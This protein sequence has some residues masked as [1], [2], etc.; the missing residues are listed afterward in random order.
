M[1]CD[2]SVII[3]TFNEE[4]N[5]TYAL[6]S[7]CGWAR[8]VLIFDSFSTDR[9]VE[10]ARA[11]ECHVLQNRFEDYGK[12]RNA[13]LDKLPIETEWVF[14]LDA[15]E[16]LPDD[17]KVKVAR[18]VAS[19]PVEDGFFCKRKLFWMGA[20]VRRG[21]YPTWILR[22]FR[23]GKARCE[24][25]TVN[26]HL[27]LDGKAGYLDADFIHE[28]RNGLPR[29]IEKHRRYAERE[30]HELLAGPTTGAIEPRLLGSQAERKRWLRERVWNRLPPLVRPFGYF[31]YR[32]VLRGGMLDGLA[33]LTYH[34][35]QG[36][37][38]PLLID[39]KYL[40]LKRRR[41]RR[42]G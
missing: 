11:Y 26:E 33:G 24:E 38:F 15:D 21:Y 2:I 29:W 9:T 16:W 35:L 42:G 5:L 30:A 6:D 4:R 22:L 25:R 20:W 23:R 41:G 32:Y 7:V 1:T 36:L 31:G 17:F 37:W 39:V 13:A 3:L 19:R 28:D 18:L 14:F 10:I 12:Q 34:T 27:V 40:Q 8:R